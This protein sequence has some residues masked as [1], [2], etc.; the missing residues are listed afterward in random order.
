MHSKLNHRIYRETDK[1]CVVAI[2]AEIIHTS[3]TRFISGV[4]C[5]V[6][7]SVSKYL[8]DFRKI[9]KIIFF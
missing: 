1:L 8:S 5:E 4:L 3:V 7:D 9:S 6:K 2:M